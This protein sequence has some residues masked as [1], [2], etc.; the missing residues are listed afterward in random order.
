MKGPRSRSRSPAPA[1][2]AGADWSLSIQEQADLAFQ[3][4]FTKGFAK[5]KGKLDGG[6][7]DSGKGKLDGGG[8]VDT[9]MAEGLPPPPPGPSISPDGL[10]WPCYYWPGGTHHDGSCLGWSTTSF[11]GPNKNALLRERFM[12]LA[13]KWEP[14]Y[15][16]LV[17]SSNIL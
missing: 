15:K 8:K 7:A 5:G 11:K 9:L 6:K 10:W 13:P 14:K 3:Y 16:S 17:Y 2:R 12:Q 4:G 1:P